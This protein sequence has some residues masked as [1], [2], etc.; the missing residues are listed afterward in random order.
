MS[1]SWWTLI[2]GGHGSFAYYGTS[3]EAA[4]MLRH[5]A[6]WEGA[7]T[8]SMRSATAEEADKGLESIRW[9]SRAGYGLDERELE[10]IAVQD[11]PGFEDGPTS[12]GFATGFE[13]RCGKKETGQ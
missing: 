8:I 3:D 4:I 11:G 1:R 6:I 2:I 10:A 9:M 5:K 7:H 12:D 13:E